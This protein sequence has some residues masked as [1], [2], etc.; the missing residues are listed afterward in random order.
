MKMKARSATARD[1]LQC[2]NCCI[3]PDKSVVLVSISGCSSSGKTS[4]AELAAEVLGAAL[5][6]QDDFYK[7]DDQIPYDDQFQVLNWEIPEALQMD[8]FQSELQS[9][10][11]TGSPTIRLMH[12]K[13]VD[14]IS[15]FG[16]P[17]EYI[18]E[19]KAK[20]RSKINLEAFQIVFVDG[21]LLF[22]DDSLKS[23][24][25]TK[26]LIRVPYE[27]L[28]SRRAA[29]EGYTTS[30]S[31]WVDP[32]FYFDEF[33]YKSYKHYH[34]H[35]FENGDVEGKLCANEIKDVMNDDDDITVSLTKLL[36]TVI[37]SFCYR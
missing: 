31:F 13:N 21:F 35:L 26:I 14:D 36:D 17:D 25:D 1:T 10:K 23:E 34:K 24:F 15:K 9:I 3:M 33:V 28:K 30:E 12:N 19:L 2:H 6:Y 4:L 27:I 8:A 16:L 20:Y 5:V 37:D 11:A 32:P 22:H 7:V 18:G 29:R